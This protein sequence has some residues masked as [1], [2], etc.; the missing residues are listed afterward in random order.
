M[1]KGQTCQDADPECPVCHGHCQNP[2]TTTLYRVDMEDATGTPMCEA[3]ANDAMESGVF[4]TEG[5][6]EEEME[7]EM[8]EQARMRKGGVP[9]LP[10]AG[11][12]TWLLKNPAGSFSFAGSV[13]VELSYEMKD[14][15]PVTDEAAQKARDFGPRLAGVKTRTWPT[16]ED[17]LAAAEALGVTVK[18]SQPADKAARSGSMQKTVDWSNLNL[19]AMPVEAV[20]EVGLSPVQEI[21]DGLGVSPVEAEA[22]KQYASLKSQAMQHRSAGDIPAA[23]VVEEQ[24]DK[25]YR[26]KLQVLGLW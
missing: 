13:P 22:I 11:T 8:A 24:A 2:A 14:G 15:S 5:E 17:A 18:E 4:A 23:R 20:A 3:C 25:L 7:M 21:A 10:G 1:A 12:G 6:G 16:R 9:G 26:N 19:D